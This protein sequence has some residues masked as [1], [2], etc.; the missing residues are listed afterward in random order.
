MGLLDSTILSTREVPY[1]DIRTIDEE[2]IWPRGR[3]SPDHSGHAGRDRRRH[4]A[5]GNRNGRGRRR[6][7]ARRARRQESAE[8]Q[9]AD[10]DRRSDEAGGD[11]QQSGRAERARAGA[12]LHRQHERQRQH[13]HLAAQAGAPEA[14]RERGQGSREPAGLRNRW[15]LG[16]L[17]GVARTT[18]SPQP[19]ST[20]SGGKYPTRSRGMPLT[21]NRGGLSSAIDWPS[22]VP[23]LSPLG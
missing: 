20:E 21:T 14:G 23:P 2:N 16:T 1:V 19:P 12:G 4:S 18:R 13:E 10:L 9:L 3:D 11:G 7:G 6:S 5:G 15:G 22:G 8:A 17:Q